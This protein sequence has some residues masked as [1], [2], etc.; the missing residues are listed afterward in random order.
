MKTF[1][2]KAGFTAMK[3]YFASF[4]ASEFV[5]EKLHP[6]SSANSFAFSG[7]LF[8]T[9][10]SFGGITFDTARIIAFP[11]EPV[12]IHAIFIFAPIKN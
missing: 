10:I 12:P 1:C 7:V 4:I 3:I 8:E 2:K 9:E 6:I 11:I 5:F